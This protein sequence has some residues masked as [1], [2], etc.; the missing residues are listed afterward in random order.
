MGTRDD[1]FSAI[2]AGDVDRMRALLDSDPSLSTAVDHDDQRIRWRTDDGT[3]LDPDTWAGP[4]LRTLVVELDGSDIGDGRLVLVGVTSGDV[5]Q[6]ALPGGAWR[7]ALDSGWDRPLRP[8]DQPVVSG[9]L[10]VA[11]PSFVVLEE[12]HGPAATSGE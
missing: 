11:G 7:V 4:D 3:P 10:A 8:G 5:V 1:L 2:A 9:A 6:V 12:H